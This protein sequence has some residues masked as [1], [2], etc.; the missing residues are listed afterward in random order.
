MYTFLFAYSHLITLSS[1]STPPYVHKL[2]WSV[3]FFKVAL[4]ANWIVIFCLFLQ[5]LNN[6]VHT[7]SFVT[8]IPTYFIFLSLYTLYHFSS[9]YSRTHMH[10]S[11]SRHRHSPQSP[12]LYSLVSAIPLVSYQTNLL[13]HSLNSSITI[14]NTWMLQLFGDWESESASEWQVKHAWHF[15]SRTQ[16]YFR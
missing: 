2:F 12:S 8:C 11:S 9:G 14:Y 3:S 10:T 5:K 15:T 16:G 1:N 6:Q 7:P 13:S 4:S